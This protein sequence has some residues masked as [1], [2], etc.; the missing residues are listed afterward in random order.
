MHLINSLQ[1]LV[2]SPQSQNY[3]LA[4]S[5]GADSM[6]LAYLF[7]KYNLNFQIAHINYHL[8]GE[9]SNLDQKVVE[10]FCEKNNVKFHL[11][12]ITEKDNQP[13]NS[14]QLWAREIRYRF[15]R[16]I[17]EQ[18]KIK[19]LV[20]AHHLNDQIETF[21]INLSKASGIKGLS[22]IPV[23]DNFLLR[24]FLD[25]TK[26]DIYKYAKEHNIEYREDLSNKKTDY[27]RNKIRHNI[28]PQLVEINDLFLENFKR[29]ISYIN[30][31]KDFIELQIEEIEQKL[32]LSS[33]ENIIFD[34]DKFAVQ[35]DFVKFEILKKYGFTQEAEIEK[36][37][38]AQ[39]GSFFIS[40]NFK[41]LVNRDQLILSEIADA[42]DVN[43]IL[44]CNK[45]IENGIDLA[46]LKIDNFEFNFNW[47]FDAEKLVFPLK[48][49]KKIEGDV[50]FPVGFYGKKK[51]SKF[52]K[53][54]KLSILAKQ[55]TWLLVDGN[56]SVLGILPYR[57]DRRFVETK[58]TKKS[59]SIFYE[60]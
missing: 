48:L 12:E 47:K 32:I 59:I 54:K 24:P 14:I 20:T 8:R 26:E 11:Y 4:V 13:E 18:E 5:G 25:I 31:A 38:L 46:K 53:D 28:V 43:F 6:V 7:K 56:D 36:I 49:R 15:F 10:D 37:F 21:I 3:L 23:N 50:F 44:V 57:Q 51:V 41:L 34:K 22:G 33:A 42:K 40:K 60:N 58:S 52:F 35:S 55:K 9:Q 16:N 19:Y 30:Q 1:K 27:L 2:Q 39:T 29:S 17:Q 45:Y